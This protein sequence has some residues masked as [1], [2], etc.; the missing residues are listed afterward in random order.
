LSTTGAAVVGVSGEADT[1]T[2]AVGLAHRTR[3]Y[4]STIGADLAGCAF[5]AACSAVI[6]VDLGIDTL[7][8]TEG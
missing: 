6:D 7:T 2:R 8:R 5:V 3:D 1:L 4:A